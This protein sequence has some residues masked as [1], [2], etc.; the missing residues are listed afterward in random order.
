MLVARIVHVALGVFWGG[1]VVFNAVFLG[2]SLAEAGPDGARVS[3]GL[4]RRRFLDVLPTTAVL[5]IL[6]GVYLLWRVSAGFAPAYMGSRGGIAYSVGMLASLVAL[7]LG[8]GVLRPSMVRAAAL[9]QA[10]AQANP[11]ARAGMLADAQAL[12]GR[13]GRAGQVVGW[14]IGIA[15]ATMAVARYL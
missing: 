1:V 11:D 2:P 10:A 13:A 12:R 9:S 4:M 14:L 6:S 3:G 8:L 15:V 5:T 7:A